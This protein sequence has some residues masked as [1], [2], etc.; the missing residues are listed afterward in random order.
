ML[1]QLSRV[2]GAIT[3]L[4]AGLLASTCLPAHAAAPDAPTAVMATAGNAEALVSFT[5]PVNDGGAV[6]TTYTA[7]AS[8]GGAFGIGAGTG[9]ITVTGLN[10]GTAYTFTVT[11]NN[12]DGTSS[13]STAS[14]SVTP[15]GTQT[16]T[17]ANP[18]AQNFGTAPTLIATA[19]SSLTPTFSS[20]TTGVCTITSGGTLTFITA[21]SCTIDADQ[22]GNTAWNA[23][24]TVTRT[25]TVNAVVPG[26]PTIGTATAGNTQ[27]TVS[28]TAPSSTGGSAIIASGY[29][30]TASPGGAT[31][32]GSSSPITVTG[33]TNSVAYTFTVTA[34]NS[35]GTGAASGAS[36]S[37]TPAAPQT[38]TFNNPGTQNFG[39]TPTLTA[40]ADS[41]LAPTF[42]SSTT[43]VCTITPSGGTLT[44]I[45]AGS[46]TINANQVGDSSYLPAS[47]VSQTFTVAAVSPGA[48]TAAVATAGDTQALIA[49]T[50]PSFNGGTA[51]TGYTVT[52][53]PADVAPVN[54]AS[55]PIVVTGLTNGQAYTFTA[56]ATNS[57]GTGSASGASNSI[58][59]AATQTITFATPGAQNFGTTPTFTATADSGLTPT[60]TSST[61][62]VCTITSGGAL[63]FITAGTCTINANQPG[64]GSYL[65]APEVSRSFTVN[66]VL[67]GAPTI[68]TATAGDTQASVTFTAPASTGGTTIT[69]YT[70]TSSP[71]GFTGTGTVS[72]ITVTGLSNGTAYT[73][74]ARTTNGVGSGSPS[75]AS[76]SVTPVSAVTLSPASL[77]DMRI[78]TAYGNSLSASGGTAPYSYALTSGA[79]PP[80]IALSSTG[81]LSGT[82][83]A[84][85][86]FS[87]AITAQDSLGSLSSKNYGLNVLPPTLSLTPASPAL[88]TTVDVAHNQ[89]FAATGGIAP[90]SYSVSGTLPTGLIFDSTTGQL[91]GTPTTPGSYGFTV[92]AAD[93]SVGVGAPFTIAQGYTLEVVGATP[94]APSQTLST[95][96]GQALE[97]D[98]TSTASGGPFTAATVVS[99][100]PASAGGAVINSV[101][102]GYQLRFV[103]AATMSGNVAISYTLTNAFSTSAPGVISIAVTPRSDPSKDAE[104]QGLINAQANTS[105]R[106]A[107]G[108]ISNFQQRL[109]ALHNGNVDSFSNGF[110]LTSASMHPQHLQDDPDA[111]QQW[112]QVKNANAKE[113]TALRA[114]A[115][116][117]PAPALSNQPGSASASP[118]AIWTAGTISIG[119]DAHSSSDADQEFV[120][121][122][123]SAGVD[124]RWSPKLTVGLGFGYG[125]DKTD[126]GDNGS[127]SEAD[128]YSVALYGSYRPVQDIYLDAVLGYQRLNF[129]NRRYVTDNGN[130]VTGERDGNQVFASL[131]AG[132]EY[133]QELWLLNPYLRLDLADARLDSYEESGDSL[134]ALSYGEQT[135][136]TSSTSLGLRSEYGLTTSIGELTPSLHMEYQH[137]FQGAGDASMRY[138]DLSGG[139]EYHTNLDALGQN[140]GLF[141]VGLGLLTTADWNLRAEYQLT[142]GSGDQQAQSVL[143]NLEKPF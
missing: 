27:A 126:I 21:G 81:T 112:L 91:S 13:A 80:G 73:F 43:G 132:Y 95:A 54:G 68:G 58:T 19:T 1:R 30:V 35:A 90:Y 66:A 138:A 100:T 22:A 139:P 88:S 10:N 64:N 115:T 123:L 24:T 113:Q 38:I 37:V 63:T 96:A 20:S 50:A 69:G 92:S 129:D 57:A 77:P 65:P 52:V 110:N 130:R 33:L 60:F 134:Y 85:G 8:P 55:S 71:G 143:F 9:T 140:R 76:N 32:T 107:S 121:S 125:H 31:A 116:D 98:L 131:A 72:P 111:M 23:A 82:P 75:A 120:T 29:T 40:T 128:S 117:E 78:G 47:Q 133:R 102:A 114:N 108:Q 104:V 99:V 118:L 48:P 2:R 56:T 3:L 12:A 119:D 103:P 17:F 87:F 70:V 18:G 124:Y 89:T 93:S 109:G 34:T 59:P 137:D 5:P 141:G 28:F 67:P 136:K 97:V 94:V 106:F 44:F 135:V 26:A 4:L 142:L 101:G 74:T 86:A 105:R 36:N 84:S 6:I 62:G 14:N 51:I 83:T 127:R 46:C 39:T 61:T 79:L 15:K 122:G 49:F 11:A 45:T 53:N 7:T 42:T 16:I 25:F 41:S